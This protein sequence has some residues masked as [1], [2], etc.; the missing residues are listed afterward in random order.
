M[1]FLK[2][3]VQLSTYVLVYY[4]FRDVQLQETRRKQTNKILSSTHTWLP[5]LASTC[6][7]VTTHVRSLKI[8]LNEITNT[9]V[10]TYKDLQ[11]CICPHIHSPSCLMIMDDYTVQ[12]TSNNQ[13]QPYSILDTTLYNYEQPDT[14]GSPSSLQVPFTYSLLHNA[15]IH[16]SS[17][18]TRGDSALILPTI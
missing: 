4:D 9:T 5:I 17:T 3:F 10:R 18:N 16:P 15:P 11:L 12:C 7:N 13:T 14:T 8:L 2:V 1:L 6:W